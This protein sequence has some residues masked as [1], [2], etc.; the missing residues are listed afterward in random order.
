MDGGD[1]REGLVAGE[2][3]CISPIATPVEGM[4]VTPDTPLAG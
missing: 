1:I 3:I 2:R 4:F